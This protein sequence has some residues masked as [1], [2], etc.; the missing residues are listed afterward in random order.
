MFR[1][2]FF[3]FLRASD[4][5]IAGAPLGVHPLSVNGRPK[6]TTSLLATNGGVVY[7]IAGIT[8]ALP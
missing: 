1:P 5:P 7:M 8:V 6:S 4:V 3:L 2:S